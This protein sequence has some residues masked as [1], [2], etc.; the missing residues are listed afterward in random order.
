MSPLY[1]SIEA[2]Q[3]EIGSTETEQ[4]YAAAGAFSSK[5]EKE[6]RERERESKK[7]LQFSSFYLETINQKL[8]SLYA[9]VCDSLCVCVR[10]VC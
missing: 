3:M 8:H 1:A 9:C 6:R 7:I 4:A 5:T 10:L 2:N